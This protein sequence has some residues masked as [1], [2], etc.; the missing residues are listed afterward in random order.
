MQRSGCSHFSARQLDERFCIGAR[1][2][3]K[4]LERMTRAG[5]IRREALGKYELI[6]VHVDATSRLLVLSALPMLTSRSIQYDA[7]PS[8]PSFP[9][10]PPR[11]RRLSKFQTWY[12]KNRTHESARKK[13][14]YGIH[15]RCEIDQEKRRQFVVK[16]RVLSHYSPSLT[17]QRCGFSDLRALTI[18]HVNGQG[19][20]HRR[21]L[22]LGS[23]GGHTFYAWLVRAGFPE[24][25]QVLCMNC[26]FIEYQQRQGDR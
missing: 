11:L 26:Q 23:R 16:V 17:C 20:I 8:P 14:Y 1:Y 4:I 19:N 21:Q 6:P 9:S 3:N 2:A 13:T 25:Y 24:G 10:L 15:R 18:D 5:Q 7:L 22:G 12:R